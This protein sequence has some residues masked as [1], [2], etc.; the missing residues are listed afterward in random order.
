MEKEVKKEYKLLTKQ[1]LQDL[2]YTGE[3]ELDSHRFIKEYE[4][5]Q[6]ILNILNEKDEDYDGDI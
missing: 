3:W 5:N 6:E 2:N 4:K 1:E